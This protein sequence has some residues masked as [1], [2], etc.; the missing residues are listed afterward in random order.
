MNLKV[1]TNQK[2]RYMHT[3][4]C[5]HD[6]KDNVLQDGNNYNHRGSPQGTRSLS[7]PQVPLPGGPAPGRGS[8]RTL[9]CECF[10]VQWSLL[11]GVSESCGNR[12]CILKGYIQ[13]ITG[14]RT[15][16]ESDDLKRMEIRSSC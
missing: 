1:T 11:S 16:G 2:P 7:Q 8:S 3:K 5:K 9:G 10:E 4:E 14:S 15:K 6:T 12:D 13:N